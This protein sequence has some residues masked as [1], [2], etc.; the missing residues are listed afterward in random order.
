MRP[1]F[2]KKIGEKMKRTETGRQDLPKNSEFPG[3]SRRT[4]HYILTNSESKKRKRKK[5]NFNNSG[6]PA[7]K[8]KKRLLF[9]YPRAP[10][11][12]NVRRHVRREAGLQW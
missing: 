10:T 11:A 8:K 2:L 3:S 6:F 4:Q 1:I 9:L 5:G 12:A 7:T